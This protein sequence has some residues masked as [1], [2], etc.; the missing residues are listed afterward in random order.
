MNPI[1]RRSFLK[2]A[3]AGAALAWTPGAGLLAQSRRARTADAAPALVC[4]YLRG[5][6][7]AMNA[8]VPYGE[9]QYYAMRPTIAVPPQDDEQGG[10]GV[11]AL[12]ATFGLHPAMRPL[13]PYWS[14]GR[15]AGV[16][17][18][19]SPHPT[20][21]HF[22]AQDF[23]EYAAPGLR[24]IKE[25]WLNRYLVATR[26]RAERKR[27]DGEFVLRAMAMQG[28]LPRSLR[29]DWPVLAVPER[30]VL[31]NRRVLDLFEDLY[32]AAQDMQELP[33]VDPVL[34]VG[35]DTLETLALYRQ[36]LAENRGERD[37]SYPAGTFGQR[38]RDLAAIL[39]A[40]VNLEVACIDV[41]GW[42]HHANQGGKDGTFTHM[43]GNLSESLAAFAEDLGGHLER[44]L[45]LVV[46]EFGR[47]CNENGNSGTDHGRGGAMFLLGGSVQGGKLYGQWDGLAER[48]LVDGRDLPVSTDFRDLFAEVLRNHLAFEPPKGFFPDY[49]PR[50]VR[51]L[52]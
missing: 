18:C 1:E 36:T 8:V 21:S 37:V 39:H 44:T 42:D 13:L 9:R 33:R 11:I 41:P 29:G 31:E 48:D 52:F 38:L 2:L 23:M 14:A 19:G 7:D 17:N 27:K 24:T 26:A 6:L 45:I 3:G 10:P 25:G 50:P 5:G 4:I 40:Q 32:G 28:L 35:R 47:T 30:R 20:R 15:L 46:T 43:L 51:G 49:T 16:I 22:D 34:E 12:D